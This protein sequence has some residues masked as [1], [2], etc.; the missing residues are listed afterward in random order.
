MSI[1]LMP[2]GSQFGVVDRHALK[3]RKEMINNKDNR[4]MRVRPI[5]H[6]WATSASYYVFWCY[7]TRLC[8]ATD[9]TLFISTT[10]TLSL[11]VLNIIHIV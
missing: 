9:L 3:Y 4:N 10:R 2:F 8:S 1:L 6:R 11:F 7:L 5:M